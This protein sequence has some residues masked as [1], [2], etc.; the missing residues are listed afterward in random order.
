[1]AKI[2]GIGKSTISQY[3]NGD[4]PISTFILYKI[5]KNFHVSAD[6]LLG[7][8]DSDPIKTTTEDIIKNILT[9]FDQE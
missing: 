1:M 3:E 6:Y 4:I 5:C 7:K 2:L 9:V 8:I